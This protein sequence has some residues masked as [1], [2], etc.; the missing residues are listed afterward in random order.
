MSRYIPLALLLIVSVMGILM[1]SVPTQIV[2]EGIDT[3][4]TAW[5][6]VSSALVLL[7]TP[8]LAY[9]YGGMVNNKNVISTMLQSFIAMGVISILW[10]VVGF[11]LA[12]GDSIGGFIGDP[13]TFFMF[14]GVLDGKPWSLAATIPLVVFAF[15]QLKFAVI[16]P[17]LVTGSMAER[18]NFRSYVLFMILFCLF[19]Y[20]PL[21]HWTWHPDG[22][23]FKMG[24]LDFAG[25][26]VVHMSAG[27]AALAG[28]IYLKRRKSHMEANYFP[29][30]NIPFVLLGTGLLWFGWFGFNAGSAVGASALAASAFATTNTAA[31]AAGLSWVLFDAAKGKKVSALGFAI[32]AV[33][34]LVAITPAA[35]F[36]TIPS[37][38]FIGSVAGMI[39][40]FVAHLRT[41]STLDDTLDVFPC[42]GVGGMV[43]MLMTGIFASKGI[44]PAV[45]V[46]GLAFG[47][48]GLFIEHVKALFIV[49]AFAFGGSLLLLKVTDLIL[50]LRVSEDD[51]KVGLDVSQHDEFLIEA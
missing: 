3:G 31:A 14:K 51:E 7:M 18:I 38:I 20:T 1:P 30:A 27:W 43:G 8:G 10:V 24:V 9:F 50:P 35:G 39:S 2:T 13:R 15:F 6:L 17:A 26:T 5:M 37:S 45:T 21:A 19:V 28:A 46:E 34:G 42:H 36:V 23:L 41:K 22:F 4:D 16:T 32:G 47:E 12:F 44:N 29:P 40:N 48:T 33:V 49:S 11:S 25:G